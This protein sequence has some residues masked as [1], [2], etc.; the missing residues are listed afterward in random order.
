MSTQPVART[1]LRCNLGRSQH[2]NIGTCPDG[3]G[4]FKRR[5]VHAAHSFASDEVD[6]M[7][8]AVQALLLEPDEQHAVMAKLARRAALGSVARKVAVLKASSKARKAA[9]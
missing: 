3:G 1:C 4:V 6:L 7:A 5:A 8:D 9:S 2:S